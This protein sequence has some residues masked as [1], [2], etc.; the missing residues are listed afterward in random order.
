VWNERLT[1]NE[2]GQR[3][4]ITK[5]EAA[6]KQFANKAASRDKRLIE[7]MIKYHTIYFLGCA[8]AALAAAGQQ[9]ST[10][11]DR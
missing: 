9:P 8:D 6:I 7:A 2:N 5:Q 10:A 1:V 11:R 4:R 3:H